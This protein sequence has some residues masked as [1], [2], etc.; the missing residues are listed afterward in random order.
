MR[1]NRYFEVGS[2]ILLLSLVWTNTAVAQKSSKYACSEPNPAQLCNADNS[3]GSPNTPCVVDV[4]RTSNASSSTASIEKPKAN[5]LFCVKPGTKV[6]WKSTGKETG[7]V[8]DIGGP[9]SPFDPAGAIIGGS[10][11]EV[12]VTAKKPG[13]YKYSAGACVSGAVYGMCGTATAEVIVTGD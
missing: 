12:S 10:D 4:K 3:C 2:A 6:T 11:R 7:F 13:C 8:V 9:T 5:A 1:S